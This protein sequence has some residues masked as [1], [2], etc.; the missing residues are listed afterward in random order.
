[1]VCTSV[2]VAWEDT[3]P[4]AATA[5]DAIRKRDNEMCRC[6]GVLMPILRLRVPQ[7]YLQLTFGS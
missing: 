1:M 3:N 7:K 6:L 4:G 2:V 5:N